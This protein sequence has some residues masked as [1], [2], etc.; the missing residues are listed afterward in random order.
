M[1][2]C[3]GEVGG[4]DDGGSAQSDGGGS[5]SGSSG[6]NG[7]SGVNFIPCP[8][9]PPIVGT[10]CAPPDHGCAYIDANTG[11]CQAFLCGSNPQVWSSTTQ[12]C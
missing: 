2:S 1:A 11:T 12:G 3:G 7:S 8:N 5:T 6:G 10:Y 9:A 4:Q